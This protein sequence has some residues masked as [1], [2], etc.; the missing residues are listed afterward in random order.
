[1]T[2]STRSSAPRTTTATSRGSTYD[3]LGRRTTID[4]PDTG[5]ITQ[6][7]DLASNLIA[8]ITPNLRA[9]G[10]AI[11]YDYRFTRLQAIHYPDL[12]GNDVTYSYGDPGAG[13]NRAGRISAVRDQSG[14]E[15]R[16]YG[17]LGETV[18]EI[19]TVASD[20]QGNSPSSPETYTTKYLYDSLNRLQSL[21]YPDGE[22]LTYGYDSGGAPNRV[23]GKK[24]ENTYAYL[25]QLE[26][27]TF[28][29]PTLQR[30]GNDVTTDYHY[31]PDNRRLQNL[32]TIIP[33]GRSLQNL[34]Y[35]YDDVGN[36]LTANSTVPGARRLLLRR[37]DDT[38]V[39]LRRPRP[40]H[41]RHRHIRLR[42]R[43]ATPLQPHAGLRHDLQHPH[44]AAVRRDRPTLRTADH[45]TE[46]LLR[47]RL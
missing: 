8:K 35:T 38:D 46:D 5:T 6:R 42:A 10:K 33:A 40:P 4:N 39:H 34:A 37:S 45:P 47:Q 13:D 19:K 41:R 7:Y 32:R 20:T 25:K 36:V 15:E 27:D 3:L 1:M 18:K 29:Q 30:L 31:R 14:T 23:S 11:T 21:T 17:K 16:F 2:R 24:G 9:T 12:P 22:V 26:Y 44:Q 28:G 43:K